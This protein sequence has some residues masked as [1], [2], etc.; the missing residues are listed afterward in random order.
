MHHDRTFVSV[1]RK[2]LATGIEHT[3]VFEGG[4][5]RIEAPLEQFMVAIANELGDLVVYR[6]R[7]WDTVL[8]WFGKQPI[9]INIEK[10]LLEIMPVL[11]LDM[12]EQTKY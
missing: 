2:H 12:K 10:R 9:P 11:V 3:V 7:W 8:G 5:V 6:K 1:S 4:G